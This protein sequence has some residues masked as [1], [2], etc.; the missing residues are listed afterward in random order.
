MSS[1]RGPVSRAKNEKMKTKWILCDD[2]VERRSDQLGSHAPAAAERRDEI[3]IGERLDEDAYLSACGGD[4][5][6]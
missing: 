2:G 4:P 6:E 5:G 3:E 1:E